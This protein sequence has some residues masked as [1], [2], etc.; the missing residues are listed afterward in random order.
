MTEGAQ[1]Q[2]QAEG[3]GAPKLERDGAHRAERARRSSLLLK[4]PV[5]G[6]ILNA[7]SGYVLI[8]DEDARILAAGPKLLED[9]GYSDLS[10]IEGKGLGECFGCP[11]AQESSKGCGF[12]GACQSCP[13]SRQA[14]AV[15][16]SGDPSGLCFEKVFNAKAFRVQCSPLVM[17]KDTLMIATM[18]DITHPRR[19]QTLEDMFFHAL[20]SKVGAME[21]LLREWADD[22]YRIS[23]IGVQLQQ[24]V[25]QLSQDVLAQKQLINV[26]TLDVEGRMRAFR[27]GEICDEVRKFFLNHEL[28]RKRRLDIQRSVDQALYTDHVLLLRV[29]VSMVTNALEAC[30]E[31]E[32][33]ALYFEVLETGVRVVV[34]NPGSIPPEVV[35]HIFK[36]GFSTKAHKGRGYGTYSIKQLGETLLGGRVGFEGK[37]PTRF[38]IDIPDRRHFEARLTEMP[39]SLEDEDTL[40]NGAAPLPSAMDQSLD[41]ISEPS[42]KQSVEP[43]KGTL[44][45]VDDSRTIRMFLQ[46][47]LSIEHQV[48]QAES[49]EAALKLVQSHLPDLILLDVVMPG[50]DGF[51]VCARLKAD[52]QT[53]DIPVIFL[54]SLTGDAEETLALEAG[55]VDFIE[56]PIRPAVVQARVRNHMELKR[57]RDRLQAIS[58]L[59]GLTGIANRRRFDDFLAVEF[60]RARRHGHPLSL[61]LGDVDFFKRFND[62]YGHGAGDEC[63]RRVADAFKT[64]L[65]RPSD[66]AARYGG[67]EF[68]CVLPDTDLQGAREV[69][70]RIHEKLRAKALPHAFSDASPQ[71]TLSLGLVCLDAEMELESFIKRADENLYAAKHAGRNR[72]MG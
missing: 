32:T 19:V 56:K 61:I 35:P 72:S 28:T 22:P 70:E 6:I 5:I 66:L 1:G 24:L 14:V 8:L 10:P 20:L 67:E 7:V 17:D 53:R 38:F 64:A 33:V 63:L 25:G 3:D 47:V 21:G 58:M 30:P 62:G 31:G 27:P 34:E 68:V 55:A 65:L 29:L 37:G 48:I 2:P 52:A 69:A 4:N 18:V 11:H 49:G 44:L 40:L 54:T 39:L 41:L 12:S 60:R 43:A 50:L 36:K 59:D 15:L 42:L 13:L 26:K 71:V 23:V 45:V 51:A 9:L 16:T 57:S 46:Q